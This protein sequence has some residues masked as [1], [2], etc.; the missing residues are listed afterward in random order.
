MRVDPAAARDLAEGY[1]RAR[2]VAVERYRRTVWFETGVSGG[3]AAAEVL[4][5]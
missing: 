4:T 5:A 1:L 2:H 3:S